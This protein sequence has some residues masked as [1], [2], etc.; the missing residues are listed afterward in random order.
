MHRK[1]LVSGLALVAVG[2]VAVGVAYA[3]IGDGGVIQACY[4]TN[5]DLHVVGTNPTVHGGKCDKGETALSWN[6]AG[7]PGKDGT[8]G[9]PGA[10][11]K[12]GAPGA[13]GKD[14]APGAPG[15]DGKDG[16]SG[17]LASGTQTDTYGDIAPGQ[18]MFNSREVTTPI[19]KIT[20]VSPRNVSPVGLVWTGLTTAET[21]YGGQTVVEARWKVCNITSATI[22][23]ESLAAVW[24]V[25]G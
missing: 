4:K 22:P 23:N 12:D 25:L 13:P 24:A 11:G 7:A 14:G 5:G 6:Q 10:P 2:V 21:T 16:S 3:A 8:D 1:W 15:K 19:D 20:V 9:A 17:V 18:C